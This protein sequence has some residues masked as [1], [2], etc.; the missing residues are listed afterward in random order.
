MSTGDY[1]SVAAVRKVLKR[2][3]TTTIAEAMQRFWKDQAA[4]NAGNPNGLTRLPPD[5]AKAAAELWEQA[6]G[7]AQASASSGDNAARERLKE[8]AAENE[9]RAHSLTLREREWETAARERER[10]LA[11][12]REHLLLL[13]TSL[14]REQ[15]TVEA[16]DARIAD[17]EAQIGQFRQQIAGLLAGAIARQR[18]SPRPAPATSV[19]PPARRRRSPVMKR[20]KQVRPKRKAVRPPKP[21]ARRRS[22]KPSPRR[23]R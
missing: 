7:L 17:L 18:S 23:K 10:A 5:F 12:A 16:R 1:P 15:A 4:L 14:S 9:V 3:S 21:A 6:L 2:G 11:D 22:P 19:E 8:I 20:G 13:S